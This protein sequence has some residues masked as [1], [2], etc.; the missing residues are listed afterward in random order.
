[1]YPNYDF[2]STLKSLTNFEESDLEE[3]PVSLRSV[4]WEM[5]KEKFSMEVN[6]YVRSLQQKKIDAEKERQKSIEE[7]IS[8]KKNKD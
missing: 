1:M 6:D 2:A 7:I 4:S 3:N 5:I 8:R